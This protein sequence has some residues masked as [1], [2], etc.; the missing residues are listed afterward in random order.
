[1]NA[2]NIKLGLI[3]AL[4]LSTVA[5]PAYSAPSAGRHNDPRA[6]QRRIGDHG[7]YQ[8]ADFRHASRYAAPR[9][10][11]V[12]VQVHIGNGPIA[13]RYPQQV[14]YGTR[15]ETVLVER[16][17]YETRTQTVL[18]TAGRWEDR[19]IPGRREYLRDSRGNLHE[20]QVTPDRVE[21]IWCPPVYK[22]RTVQVLIPA[23][24]ETRVV[25]VPVNDRRY[26]RRD[27]R[28]SI[29]RGAIGVGLQ[30]LGQIL[31]R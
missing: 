24:Y 25:R 11:D 29:T 10:K 6:N 30:V 2:T 3:G 9:R 31:A 12:N 20:I 19:V 27:S 4:V 5:L 7:R 13:G 8:K 18:V 28:T 22:T 16:A 1:M 14:R 15:T 17:H 21:R 26:D 23:R